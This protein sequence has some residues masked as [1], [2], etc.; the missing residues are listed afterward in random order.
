MYKYLSYNPE[1]KKIEEFFAKILVLGGND[2]NSVSIEGDA[3]SFLKIRFFGI[4]V[5]MSKNVPIG[6]V[7]FSNSLANKA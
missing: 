3:K 2:I 1:D 6:E 4:Q 5:V 7:H